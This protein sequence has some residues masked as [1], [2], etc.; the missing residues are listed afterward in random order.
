[1]QTI[2]IEIN[3]DKALKLIEELEALNLIRIIRNNETTSGKKLS[4]RLVGSISQEQA[5]R[6]MKELEQMRSEWDR[7]I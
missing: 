3:N 7:D 4:D 1:M 6:M 5:D 2:T